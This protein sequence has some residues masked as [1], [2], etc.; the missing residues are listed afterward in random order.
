LVFLCFIEEF[1]FV[2]QKKSRAKSKKK[3]VFKDV[4]N[5]KLQNL[6]ALR[7]QPFTE[8]TLHNWAYTR[9]ALNETI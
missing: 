5:K 1:V 6:N 3:V 7:N 8:L 4:Q 9:Y 2:G